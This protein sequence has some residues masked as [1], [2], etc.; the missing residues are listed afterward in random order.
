[1]S[2]YYINKVIIKGHNFEFNASL[3]LIEAVELAREF[4]SHNYIYTITEKISWIRWEH[5]YLKD[6]EK[7]LEEENK[8]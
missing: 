5:V 3:S 2:E 7:K 4:S 6:L 8:K 1:M